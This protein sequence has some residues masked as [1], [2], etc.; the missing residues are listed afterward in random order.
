MRRMSTRL[1]VLLGLIVLI[2]IGFLMACGSHYSSSS[3]GLV[4]VP[5]RGSGVLQSFSFDLSSGH[6]SQ[7]NTAPMILGKPTAIA[8]DTA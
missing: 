6:S 2:S 7:I 3:D 1:T 5:S 8:I 4:L